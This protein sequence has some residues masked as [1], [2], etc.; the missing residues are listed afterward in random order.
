M[1]DLKYYFL[2]DNSCGWQ[3][4]IVSVTDEQLREHYINWPTEYIEIDY[5]I[6]GKFLTNILSRE[7]HFNNRHFRNNYW[8]GW[9]ISNA[10]FDKLKRIAEI[11]P[12]VC[13]YQRL[14]NN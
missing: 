7:V 14:L 1:S 2:H 11:Y 3:S 13:E 4:V 12:V 6:S 10:E 9:S 8:S 5:S